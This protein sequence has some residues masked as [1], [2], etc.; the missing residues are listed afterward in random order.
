MKINYKKNIARLLCLLLALIIAVEFFDYRAG[1]Y[2][3]DFVLSFVLFPICMVTH[4]LGHVIGVKLVKGKVV[5][6]ELG[7][8]KKLFTFRNIHFNLIPM[9][10]SVSFTGMDSIYKILVA[11]LSGIIM[12]FIVWQLLSLY[13]AY[14]GGVE[15]LKYLID[16]YS[17][18]SFVS[19]IPYPRASDARIALNLLR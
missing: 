13:V 9:A 8:G 12:N 4:E 16:C 7:A 17:L 2:K 3:M 19:I 14:Y 1:G 15:V 6:V 10:G 11:I 5:C 18:H